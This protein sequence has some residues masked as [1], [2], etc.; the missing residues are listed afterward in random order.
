MT[1]D[2][3]PLSNRVVISPD[4]PDDRSRGGIFIPTTA[5]DQ[6]QTGTVIAVGPGKVSDFPVV[7][8]SD[9]GSVSTEAEFPRQPMSIEEGMKVLVGKYSGAEIQ[10]ERETFL[11]VRE[12]DILSIV[13]E[14][15]DE[16]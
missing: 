6:P 3:R 12:T 11:V 8:H 14:D 4:D 15:T 7:T 9:D 5:Q 13:E 10:I 16:D 2:L 1:V